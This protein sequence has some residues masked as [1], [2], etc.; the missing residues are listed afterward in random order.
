MRWT[1]RTIVIV[2]V[3]GVAHAAWPFFAL[4]DLVNA[5]QNRDS[6]AVARRVNFAGVRQSLT[7]QIV[8]SYL[9]LSG[10]DARLGQF[11][12]GMAVAAVTA[13]ADPIVA[14][15]LSAEAL[16]DLLRNG[17]PASALLENTTISPENALAAEGLK[18]GSLGSAWQ[19][20]IHSEHGLRRFD[21]AVPTTAPPPQRFKLQF[22]LT[23]WTWKLS[24]LELPE[25]L[26]TRLAQELMKQI[27][28]K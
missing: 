17:W 19:L 11:G 5:I 22:R 2:A 24:G 10:K 27:D 7:E 13:V 14:K 20:F 28:K 21:V 9:Q 18:S 1:I 15:L 4:Y 25:V 16:V 23:N 8:V 6:A 3:L 12:R 26:R